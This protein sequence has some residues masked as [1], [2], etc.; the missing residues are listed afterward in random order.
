[1]EDELRT[2][3]QTVRNSFRLLYKFIIKEIIVLQGSNFYQP[4][5]LWISDFNIK[6]NNDISFK[7]NKWVSLKAAL[8]YNRINRTDRENLLFTYG[9]SF[10]RSF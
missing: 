2:D 3:Y 4:S 1:L 10:E 8:T 7:L 5:M 9:I 6:L